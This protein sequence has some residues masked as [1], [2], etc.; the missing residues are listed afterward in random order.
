MPQTIAEI[1]EKIH[2]GKV[3]VM[4]AK[5]LKARVREVGVSPLASD[6]LLGETSGSHLG[7]WW[8]QRTG[9]DAVGDGLLSVG[10][11]GGVTH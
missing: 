10:I 5:E 3:R 7:G 4:T 11:S 9:D 2:A 1:N 6:L 8:L